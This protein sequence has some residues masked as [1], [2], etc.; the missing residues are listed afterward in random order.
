MLGFFIFWP[1]PEHLSNNNEDVSFNDDVLMLNEAV[2]TRQESKPPPPPSPQPP[3]PVPN[4]VIIEEEID[5]K[6]VNITDFSDSISTT[7]FGQTGDG[8]E[9]VSSPQQPPRVTRIVEATT[10]QAA[11]EANIKAEVTVRLLVNKEGKVEDA[12]I[13]EIH[14][15]E[16][17]S[18]K[19]KTVDTIG[20]GISDAVLEAALQWKFHPAQNNSKTVKAYSKQIFTFG[21]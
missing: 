19:T 1:A 20:Y 9:I 14:L 16:E 12:S 15:Y 2:V 21:F 6:D 7:K 10:P 4:D 17:G 13:A 18:N 8:D 11:Q 5:F 3:I